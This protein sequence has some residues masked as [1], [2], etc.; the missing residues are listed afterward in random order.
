[1]F[2]NDPVLFMNKLIT[3]RVKLIQLKMGPCQPVATDLP[4]GKFPK[5]ESN[6]SHSFSTSYYTKLVNQIYY[7]TCKLFSSIR[8]QKN[9]YVTTNYNSWGH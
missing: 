8:A 6:P 2:K 7:W 4:N 9:S 3:P 5:D 1:M